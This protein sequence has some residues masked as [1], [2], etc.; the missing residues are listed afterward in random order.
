MK[1]K[2][3]YFIFIQS[4]IKKH[5]TVKKRV[6]RSKSSFAKSNNNRISNSHI[7]HT[8]IKTNKKLR[9]SPRESFIY[10]K[11][12]FEYNSHNSKIEEVKSYYNNKL[13][14]IKKDFQNRLYEFELQIKHLTEIT[15][16]DKEEMKELYEKRITEL[17]N[18]IRKMQINNEPKNKIIKDNKKDFEI[19][20]LTEKC[21]VFVIL[22]LGIIT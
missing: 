14:L 2:K 16:K 19:K 1:V 6:N 13:R 9:K 12:L 3:M 17:E 5:K 4:H 21:N 20:K 10:Q 7:T 18:K 11:Y 15:E 22:I 8:N